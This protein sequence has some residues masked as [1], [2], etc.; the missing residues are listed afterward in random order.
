MST[1][2]NTFEEKGK[3]PY[4]ELSRYRHVYW[5]LTDELAVDDEVDDVDNNYIKKTATAKH[6]D[7]DGK[8]TN[9][10]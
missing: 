2:H 6:S 4:Q 7:N 5:V 3:P 9:E 1:N 10:L 8:N